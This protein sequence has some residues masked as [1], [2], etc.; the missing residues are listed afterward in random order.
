MPLRRDYTR[1]MGVS[2]D[3]PQRDTCAR[4]CSIP[5]DMPLS[6]ARNLNS[7]GATPCPHFIQHRATALSWLD[8]PTLTYN[9]LRR[10]GYHEIEDVAALSDHD[11]RHI[12]G[13]GVQG[14]QIIRQAIAHWHAVVELA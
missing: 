7:D 5:D 1:C 13:I 6:W 8:L 4:H 10:A 2:P 14:V 9:A 3:C 12:R 11:L